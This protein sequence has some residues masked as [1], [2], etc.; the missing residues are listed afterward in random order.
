[1]ELLLG[2]GSQRDRRLV[3]NGQR[4][5]S[6]LVTLDFNGDHRPDIVHDLEVYPWP[7]ETGVFHEVHAY[8][9]VEHLGRQGDYRAFFAFFA[10]VYRILEPGGFFAAT[11]PSY[12]SMWAWGDPSHT[13]VIT[14][15]SLVFLD[16]DQY[17]EQVGKT[18]MSDFRWLW[19]HDF[20]AVWVKEDDERL[21]FV[22]QA[23][24]PSRWKAPAVPEGG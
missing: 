6:K 7:V 22:I 23:V 20:R 21:A 11:C 8:E 16:Q 18:P 3:V 5:W 17:V 12:R 4:G 1:M 9:L 19:K 24:K 10:E 2:C 15:G 13:R 14:S